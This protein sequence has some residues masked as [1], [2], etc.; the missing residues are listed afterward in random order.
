MNAVP[1]FA[2]SYSEARAKFH[3]AATAKGLRITSH[4]NPTRG[5]TGEELATDT[6]LIGNPSASRLLI[7]MSG[8]HGAE[9]FCGSG[10]QVGW[11][12]EGLF[13]SL[14]GD[15]AVLLIHAINPSGFA[16][17]RRVNEDNIDL[18][19]NFIDHQGA[20]P[21]NDGYRQLRDAICP[22]DWSVESERRNKAAFSAYAASNGALALQ[23]AITSGQYWDDA[24][25]FYGGT[26]ETWSNRTL[27][28]ILAPFAG[29]AHR[30]AFI[31][32]HTGLG[33]YGFGEIMSNHFGQ[34]VGNRLIRDWWGAE[35]TFFDD[36]STSSAVTI[37]DTN[38]GVDQALPQTEVAGI[39]LE[40]GTIP[41]EPMID[42][43]RADNWLH[44]HGKLDSAL[45]KEIKAEIRAGFYPEHD[46]WKQMVFE[47]AVYVLN[48]MMRGLTQS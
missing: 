19:R 45:G 47:R 33:P 28:D 41:L 4:R 9:G 42:A 27:R 21:E 35:A 46:D 6:T 7:G 43:V 15:T 14:P 24:G 36:G 3:D 13:D 30:A 17:V 37:G 18:N 23:S 22:A 48:G 32:L 20:K 12:Q 10:I 40:Y 11:L 1:F 31:D 25:V 26:T 44:L 38:I 2:R 29:T 39:T 34:S 16:W 8:T 5:P